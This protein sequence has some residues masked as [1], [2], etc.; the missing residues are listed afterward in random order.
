MQLHQNADKNTE[1][2]IKFCSDILFPNFHQHS[3][4]PFMLISE[5]KPF[6]VR[7]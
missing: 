2:L 1:K 3:I 4:V 5:V 7:L 6:N